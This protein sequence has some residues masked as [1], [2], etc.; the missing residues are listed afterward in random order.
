[1][2][3]LSQFL[4]KHAE[5]AHW[6]LF[7]CAI[8]AG[9]N[10]PISVDVL[11]LLAAFLAAAIIP[12]HLWHLLLSVWIGCY[13]SAWCAYGVG[14]FLGERLKKY[15]WFCKILPQ[16]KREKIQEFYKK[17]GLWTLLV[18]RFIP[19][20]VRNAIFMTSGMSKMRFSRFMMMDAFACSLWI[21]SV[22]FLC[23]SLSHHY[24]WIWKNLKAFNAVIFV[25][26]G[27][28]VIGFL[29]YKKRNSKRTRPC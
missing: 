16:G 5:H 8:L 6:Y 7:A 26:F 25:A 1:M 9:F 19:F 4:I 24:E 17:Y 22:F 12:E 29:W 18:G 21:F 15:S 11:I 10:V 27:V 2:E 13:F 23:H 3:S 14:R 28:T 20:G